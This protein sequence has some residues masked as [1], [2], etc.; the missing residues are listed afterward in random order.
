[1]HDRKYGSLDLLWVIAN[2]IE[3]VKTAEHQELSTDMSLL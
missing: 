2:N 1:M 3:T